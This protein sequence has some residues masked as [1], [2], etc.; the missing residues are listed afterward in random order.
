MAEVLIRNS[1]GLDT[2]EPTANDD[3]SWSRRY[4]AASGAKSLRDGRKRHWQRKLQR[5]EAKRQEVA[6]AAGM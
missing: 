2:A 1:S 4:V 3:A 5:L 6:I